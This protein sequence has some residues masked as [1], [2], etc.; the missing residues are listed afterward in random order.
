MGFYRLEIKT[1][2]ARIQN[3]GQTIP[4]TIVLGEE[5]TTEKGRKI[6]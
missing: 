3:R 2:F 4:G 6:R 5:H 1:P